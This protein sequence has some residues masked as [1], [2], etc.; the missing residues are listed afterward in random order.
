MNIIEEKKMTKRKRYAILISLGL[1]GVFLAPVTTL[2]AG[3]GG[4]NIPYWGAGGLVACNGDVCSNLCQITELADHL[5]RFGFTILL[6]VIAPIMIVAGGGM[7]LIAGA[8]ETLLSKGKMILK[9]A[10]VG[11]VL[12]L[13]AYV[14]VTTFLWLIG[15]KVGGEGINWPVVQCSVGEAPGNTPLG[16][17]AGGVVVPG[18][19]DHEAI[20]KQLNDAG[21]SV[22]SSGGCSDPNNSSCTSYN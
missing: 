3:W 7:I 13:L 5:I 22:V 17:P 15:N 18:L 2:A 20:L 4:L 9:G 10:V 6:F 8:S 16:N 19:S 1:V 11:V 12:A 21:I 14:I